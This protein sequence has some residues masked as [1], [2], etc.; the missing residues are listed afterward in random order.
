[1]Y[2]I[3]VYYSKQECIILLLS[4][5]FL[6]SDYKQRRLYNYN[7]I[8]L[9]VAMTCTYHTYMDVIITWQKILCNFL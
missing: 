7:Q 6:H 9:D 1:M 8:Y 4:L 2:D 5:L 3:P